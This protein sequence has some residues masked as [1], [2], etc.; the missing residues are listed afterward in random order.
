MSARK[1]FSIKVVYQTDLGEIR[2]SRST[3]SD[4]SVEFLDS[5]GSA[6]R[7]ST[8]HPEKNT[9]FVKP[10]TWETHDKARRELIMRFPGIVISS[11]THSSEFSG[12]LGLNPWNDDA[13]FE[14][15]Q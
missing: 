4:I 14:I 1:K 7:I 13:E 12:E 2:A 8:L 6:F 3:G 15:L 11:A 9:E 10:T 5:A